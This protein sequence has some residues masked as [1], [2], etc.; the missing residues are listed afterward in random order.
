MIAERFQTVAEGAIFLLYCK[1]D[2]A[3]YTLGGFT[4]FRHSNLPVACI[5]SIAH[6]CH[7][8]V[9]LLLVD[10]KLITQGQT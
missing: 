9:V 1:Y 3:P 8:S 5:G 10:T 6:V 7:G 4:F 2:K